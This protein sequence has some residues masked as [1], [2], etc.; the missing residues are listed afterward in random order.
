PGA[1]T[2]RARRCARAPRAA[3]DAG[4]PGPAWARRAVRHSA[5]GARVARRPSPPRAGPPTALST[6]SSPPACDDS[7]RVPRGFRHTDFP[8][9]DLTAVSVVLPARECA[10]TVGPIVR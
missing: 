4:R 1:T 6:E 5:P 9:L 10:E 7:A 2:G 3:P 8:E